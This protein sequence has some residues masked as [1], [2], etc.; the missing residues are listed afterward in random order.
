MLAPADVHPPAQRHSLYRDE[1]KW[2][3]GLRADPSDPCVM[4][5]L[6]VD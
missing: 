3:C 4:G 5:V 1:I 6:Y 2:A